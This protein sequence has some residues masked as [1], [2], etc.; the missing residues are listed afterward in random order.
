MDFQEL[1]DSF[2]VPCAVLAVE[3]TAQNT[4]ASIHI[5][6]SNAIYQ[7]IMGPAYYDGMPYEELVPKDSKFE[8]FCY[9]AAF[10]HQRLHAYVPTTALNS[11]T[12][13]TVIPLVSP[14]R[15]IGYC[16]FF[17]EFTKAADPARMAS[18]SMET[19]AEIIKACINL[20][21]AGNFKD[22][23]H[24]VLADVNAFARSFAC[25]IQ[26]IDRKHGTTTCFSEVVSTPSDE[27]RRGILPYELVSQWDGLIGVS[28]AVM[29]KDQQD[30][31]E[32]RS[33]CPDWAA[34]LDAY[35]V[36]SLVLLPLRQQEEIFGYLYVVNFDVARVVQVK[37]LLELLTYFLSS[38]ISNHLLLKRLDEMSNLDALTGVQNRNAMSRQMKKLNED[39]CGVPFGIVSMDVNGLKTTNDCYGHMAGD[40]LLIHAAQVINQV[41][42]KQD[43]YRTGGDE[44]VVIAPNISQAVFFEK[45]DALRC[46]EQ[47]D[48]SVHFAIG[49]FWSDGSVD[50]KTAFVRSDEEMYHEKK[51][52]YLNHPEEIRRG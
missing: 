32:L 45:V 11:W 30:M 17:F 49:A 39:P 16:Q 26:L 28:N 21:G 5:L 24:K 52:F 38:E 33:Q 47:Q 48:S 50:L 19:S 20:V 25:R 42:R 41:F 43:L 4:C 34:S 3:R 31:N 27:A 22:R 8:D 44:F 2:A 51:Q 14:H 29:V 9:R 10:L 37:E 40:Q 18:L 1:V 13:Q 7:Q 23:V 36:T 46:L 12:D 15:N 35:D 6:R